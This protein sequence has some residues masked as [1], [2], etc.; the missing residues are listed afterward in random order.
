MNRRKFLAT[1]AGAVAAAA[2]S[3]SSLLQGQPASSLTEYDAMDAIAL[4]EL[5]RTRQVSPKELL[6]HAIT[7][8]EAIN[9]TIKAVSQKYYDMAHQAI[10]TG[11]P[12]GPLPRCAF[13]A[14]RH[15]C[16]YERHNAVEWFCS[17]PG[18]AASERG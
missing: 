14:Q 7:R 2:F 8:C 3:G 11:L 18:N 4:A 5:V 10:R 6:E 15:G 12:E 16:G 1:T 9:P 17:I 13:S